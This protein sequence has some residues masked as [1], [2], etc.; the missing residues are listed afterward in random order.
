MLV[1]HT[2]MMGIILVMSVILPFVYFT[3]AIKWW[4]IGA[5]VMFAVSLATPDYLVDKNWDK[6][7]LM[8]PIVIVWGLFSIAQVGKNEANT[9]VRAVRRNVSRLL[10]QRI[11]R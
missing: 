2:I 4:V 7:F 10:P 8:A 3:L 6:D 9:R 11:N 5:V 1:P